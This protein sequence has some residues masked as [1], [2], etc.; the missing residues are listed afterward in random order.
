MNESSD[1]RPRLRDRIAGARRGFWVWRG[2]RPF[3][4][5]LFTLA[6]GLPI[7][8]FPYVRLTPAG[9]PLALSTTA[10]ASSLVIGILLI[11]LGISLWFHHQARLFAGVAGMLLALASFPLANFGGL[12]IGLFLGLVGGS[13]ACAWAPPDADDAQPAAPLPKQAAH[14]RGTRER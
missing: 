5:G 6:A 13:L 4:A 3:W 11:V 2:E 1:P 14:G 12:F 7:I 9:I 8:Y 10:G